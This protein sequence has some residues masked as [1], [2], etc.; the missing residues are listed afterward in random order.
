MSVSSTLRAD[1]YR[2]DMAQPNTLIF[3]DF[4]S[5][6]PA[7]TARFYGEVFNWQVE[8]RPEGV[9]HRIVPGG[10][11]PNPDGSDS[12]VGNLHLGIFSTDL[13]PPDPNDEPA[14]GSGTPSGPAPRIYVLVSDDDTEEE[15]L[16][17]AEERG[18]TILW[19]NKYWGEFNGF[20]G[21]F[22]DPWGTEI[23]VWTKGGDA[24]KV[25]PDQKSWEPAKGYPTG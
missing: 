22:R 21:A 4:P 19:R 9:F 14:Q 25:A 23:I 16:R 15:I 13:A 18:A 1:D 17:R 5:P 6:D 8:G 11:F 2:A 12:Q 24:P 10:F 7:K 3:V 20:H